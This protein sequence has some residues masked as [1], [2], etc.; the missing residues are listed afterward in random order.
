[1]ATVESPRRVWSQESR[2]ENGKSQM[3]NIERFED[4]KA[5]EKARSLVKEIYQVTGQGQLRK[6]FTLRDQIR[7]AAVSIISNIAEGFSRQTDQEFI[8]FLFISKGSAAEVQSQFY[9]AIDEDYI[10]QETFDSSY[11]R[12]EVVARQLS[13]FITYLKGSG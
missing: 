3:S 7:R 12:L 2:V 13:R 8:Q 9:T 6:D 10:S 11:E 4:I 1:M 5:W